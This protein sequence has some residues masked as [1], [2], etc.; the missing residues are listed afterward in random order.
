MAV[1]TPHCAKCG[2]NRDAAA[3]KLTRITWLLP[4]LMVVFDLIG[5]IGLGFVMR[6][7]TGAILFATLPTLLLGFVYAGARQ[8]LTKLRVPRGTAVNS[9]DNAASSATALKAS[10]SE[11]KSRQY[12]FMVSLLPPRPVR[13]TRRAKISMTVVLLTTFAVDAVLIENLYRIWFRTR[14]FADFHGGE[15]FMLCAIA[16]IASFPFFVRRRMVRDHVL[17]ENGA[18]AMARVIRQTNFK[19]N[20]AIRYEFQDE[21]G[22][23]ISGSAD[24]LTRSLYEGM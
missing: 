23:K 16:L 6:N 10:V 14:S 1:G 7:W 21:A 24:D 3:R 4:A 17:M 11:E 22:N 9:A 8:G 5:I 18:V 19:N 15:I 2:W 20:S 13:L 12:N